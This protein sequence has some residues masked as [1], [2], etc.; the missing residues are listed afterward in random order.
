MMMTTR[1]GWLSNGYISSIRNIENACKGAELIPNPK[2][3]LHLRAKKERK[4]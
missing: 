4:L 3:I 2:K 1:R